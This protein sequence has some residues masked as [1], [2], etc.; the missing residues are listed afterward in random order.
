MKNSAYLTTILMVALSVTITRAQAQNCNTGKVDPKVAEF[1][2]MMPEDNRSVE[3]LK[4]TTN[5]EV[6][7]KEGPPTI[8]YPSSDVERIKITSD[9]IPVLVFNPSRAKGLPI[10]I[11]YHGGGFI[12]PLIPG[13]E[14]LNW[15]DGKT[16]SAIVFSVDY[17]VAPER[18]FPVAVNDCYNAFKWIS[19]NGEQFGGDTSRIILKGESAGANLV[20]AVCQK[21]KTDGIVKKIKLQVMNCPLLDNPANA[22]QYPS[23]QQNANGYFLTKA[24]V[25]FALE[26]YADAADF[27]NSDFAPILSKD[28]SGLP[29]AVII[30]AEFDPLR[31]QG[32]GY[33]ERLREAS[34]KVWY[35][36]FPGQIHVLI[37]SSNETSTDLD[38]LVLNAMKEVMRQ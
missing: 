37:G 20:A 24:G 28:L 23:M 19:E 16:F 1:L 18:K 10:I 35:K 8:P 11:A 14:Y 30:T 36:C 26:T 21:A 27:N 4:K 9:S 22:E 32:V 7:K 2:K 15:Q 33:A 29:P 34:V 6:Y 31:D 17:R 12:S 25:L 3:E 5:F 38:K 13:H